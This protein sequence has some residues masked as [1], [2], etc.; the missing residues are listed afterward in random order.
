MPSFRHHDF[1]NLYIQFEVKFP[2]G[3]EMRNLKLLEEVLPPRPSQIELPEDV[4]VEDYDLEEVDPRG[5]ARAQ[6]AARGD[7]DEEDGIPHG[8][9]RMQCA[10]Q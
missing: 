6:G 9:E 1:G 5:Q 10:S 8:T 3:E 7:E 2:K 4:M